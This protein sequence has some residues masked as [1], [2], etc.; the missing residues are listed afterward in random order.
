MNCRVIIS[1]TKCVT[2]KWAKQ[3]KAEERR[4]SQI[5]NRRD[6]MTRSCRIT[7]KDV[8]YEV[9]ESAY[10]KASSDGQYP[11]HARQ[12]MYAARPQILEEADCDNLNDA[13]FSQQLLPDYMREYPDVVA[14]WD[15]V[16]DARGHLYEPHTDKEV[17]LG[18]L[19]VRKYLHD[20]AGHR[21]DN[22]Y[23]TVSGTRFYPTKGPGNRYG[24]ILFIEKEGF[25]PLF[26]KA[27]IAEKYD[28]AIMSSKGMS[29]TAS[30]SVVDNLCDGEMPLLILH[31]FDKAGFSIAGTLRRDTRRYAFINDVNAIDLGLRL[32]DIIK[33]D[34]QSE[35]C[36]LGKT[37]PGRNLRE[38]GA[39]AEEIE[40]LCSGRG[41][42][43][44]GYSGRRVELNAFSSG[45]FV[46]WVEGKLA[47]QG[48]KK[49]IPDSVTIDTAY[50]RA[51]LTNILEEKLESFIEEAEEEVADVESDPEQIAKDVKERLKACPEMSWDQAIR[52]IV[53]EARS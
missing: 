29:T 14:D 18:T 24:A 26:R 23:P 8:A 7:I 34:L 33:Y 31:D 25:M 51:V 35:D 20:I 9:M 42:H 12:I 38:N 1:S 53:E 3:R 41:S 44:V 21:V 16:F 10:L 22:I 46:E 13:Y 39:T 49:V 17:A 47:E 43:R 19:D 48:I 28:I 36:T 32:A 37:H 6:A 11:A 15:V 52:E 40:F 50:R 4:A 27:K 30:R 45:V 2:N 5:Y